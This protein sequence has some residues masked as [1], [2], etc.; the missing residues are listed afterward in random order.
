MGWCF[1]C[2]YKTTNTACP[3]PSGATSALG[4]SLPRTRSF[5][6]SCKRSPTQ[7]GAQHESCLKLDSVVAVM[8]YRGPNSLIP[9]LKHH[10]TLMRKGLM[11]GAS[12]SVSSEPCQ[13]HSSCTKRR[14]YLVVLPPVNESKQRRNK[15]KQSY[16]TLTLCAGVG[17]ERAA[18]QTCC[19]AHHSHAHG[20]R[21]VGRARRVYGCI[22]I[23][24][25]LLRSVRNP[26][27]A[28]NGFN[29]SHA[30]IPKMAEL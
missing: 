5:R 20:C 3:A 12:L 15:Q 2:G 4:M 8:V 19:P 22:D 9:K 7:S 10:I 14:M 16:M 30:H 18:S 1:I 29:G 23:L 6:N 21:Q 26:T 11:E 25:V 24:P 13:S 17:W 27:S 28:L